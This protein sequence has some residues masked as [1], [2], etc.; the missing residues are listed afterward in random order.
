MYHKKYI[1]EKWGAA[2]IN[3]SRVVLYDFSMM[4]SHETL[5]KFSYYLGQE[6]DEYLSDNHNHSSLKDY[7]KNSKLSI[8]DVNISSNTF[9]SCND[10]F[11]NCTIL[12][13]VEKTRVQTNMRYPFIYLR[14]EEEK[15]Q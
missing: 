15:E 8:K 14:E 1:V 5:N 13:N 7:T 3:Y 9:N 2:N 6:N 4:Y 10:C 11:D 12:K